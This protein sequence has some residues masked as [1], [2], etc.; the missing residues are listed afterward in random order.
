MSQK[1]KSKKTFPNDVLEKDLLS[2]G[3]DYVIGID[4][5]GRGCWAGPVYVGAFLFSRST[6]VL[7]GINDSKKVTPLKR[8]ILHDQ[9]SI[10]PASFYIQIGS[11]EEINQSGI[12]NTITMAIEKI[13]DKFKHL[14]A[15]Y[16]IDGQFKKEFGENS[17]KI[18]KGDTKHYSIS[19]ASV[20]AKVERDRYMENISNIYDKWLFNLNKGYGT[21][22]HIDAIKNFGIS[23]IHRTGYKPIAAFLKHK[24]KGENS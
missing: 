17:R 3:F 1:L 11:I 9:I 2:K 6:I 13:L 21:A 8:S 4:E 23:E 14:N 12:G 7:E 18:I 19:A 10:N 15:Y 22:K 16:L 5:V 24:A 20:V